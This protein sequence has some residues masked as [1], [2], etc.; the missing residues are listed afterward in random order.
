[1]TK[2]VRTRT[3]STDAAPAPKLTLDDLSAMSFDELE[4][5]FLGGTIPAD[6]SALDNHPK[7]RMVAV[8]GLHKL[9]VHKVIVAASKHVRFPWDGKSLSSTGDLT[10]DGINRMKLGVNLNLFPFKTRIEPSVID[11][12][13]AIYLDYEQKGNPIFIKKIR[14]ELR[15]IEPGLFLGPAMWKTG[16]NSAALVLW[17][18]LDG[19]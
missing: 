9:P 8:R 16:K 14:D 17:F 5:L 13:P 2:A 18:A 6:M 3:P 11:G 19:R 7:G 4:A 10:S 12:E 15:E 1:M